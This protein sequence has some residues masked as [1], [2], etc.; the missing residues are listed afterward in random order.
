MDLFVVPLICL[1]VLGFIQTMSDSWLEAAFRFVGLGGV[2]NF[3]YSNYPF[4]FAFF[5]AALIGFKT[6]WNRI[7]LA[8]SFFLVWAFF[9]FALGL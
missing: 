1:S 6:G 9:K 8:L 2:L 4:L 5:T 7:F 3:I